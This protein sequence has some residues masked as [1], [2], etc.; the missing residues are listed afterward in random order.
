MLEALGSWGF[1]TAISL[2]GYQRA[3]RWPEQV[4]AMTA[5]G[6][7]LAETIN[8]AVSEAANILPMTRARR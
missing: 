2:T 6:R 3:Q 4:G 7:M 5:W 8:G 1:L